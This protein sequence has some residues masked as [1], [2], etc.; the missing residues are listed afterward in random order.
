MLQ[1]F[2]IF[3]SLQVPTLALA[4]VVRKD[5]KQSQP[6]TMHWLSLD[7]SNDCFLFME[8]GPTTGCASSYAISS[9]RTLRS[10]WSTSGLASS[11]VS[12]PRQHAFLDLSAACVGAPSRRVWRGQCLL[13]SLEHLS[14]DP[15]NRCRSQQQWEL[16][17]E[18]CLEACR[19]T[20]LTVAE[21]VSQT[22]Q[23]AEN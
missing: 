5:C 13:Y 10:P 22:K 4:S 20:W 23:K 14:S 15:Q 17:M 12:Q 2:L 9:T 6:V 3:F 7:I 18:G 16:G 8:G 11:A 19:P 21:A 1:L